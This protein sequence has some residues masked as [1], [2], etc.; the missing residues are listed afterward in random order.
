MKK[1]GSIEMWFGRE[2]DHG[3]CIGEGALVVEKAKGEWSAQEYTQGEHF[4]QRHLDD[5]VRGDE[6]CDFLQRAGLKDWSFRVP[7]HGQCGALRELHCSCRE[8]RQVT[9]MQTA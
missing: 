7:W 2:T 4:P 3:C 5:K 8:V 1:A 9:W 6:Y